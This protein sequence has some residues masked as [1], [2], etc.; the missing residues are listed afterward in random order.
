MGSAFVQEDKMIW[1]NQ[2]EIQEHTDTINRKRIT[3][4]QHVHQ[5]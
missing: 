4:Y 2:Q 1:H 5:Y 3:R